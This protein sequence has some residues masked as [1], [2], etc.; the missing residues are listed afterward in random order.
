MDHTI[1]PRTLKALST[2]LGISL[3]KVKAASQ[4][5]QDCFGVALPHRGELTEQQYT[6]LHQALSVTGGYG[7]GL[8]TVFGRMRRLEI[9]AQVKAVL[10]PEVAAEYHQRLEMYLEWKEEQSG[11]LT[12]ARLSAEL[13]REKGALG[14]WGLRQ[15]RCAGSQKG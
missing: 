8:K 13:A 4:I 3:P 10:T 7:P 14:Y 5:Y 1:K 9:P 12:L 11:R 15:G 2:E 6:Q